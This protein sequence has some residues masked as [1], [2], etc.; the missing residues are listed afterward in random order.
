MRVVPSTLRGWVTGVFAV[1]GV[2]LL[3]WSI[4][5][6]SS[7]KAH[8]ET[9]RWDLAWSGFDTGLAVL[10]IATAVAL[11]RRSPWVGVLAAA[12]G[13]GLVVDAWFDIILES[14]ADEMRN[15]ILLAVFAELPIAAFCFWVA[16]RT[17]RFHDRALHLAA[18]RQRAAESDLVGVLEVPADREPT[19]E[20]RH[21]DP[22]A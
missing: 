4:W 11:H 5:L 8:H 21:A 14:H 7:L 16:R 1:C 9:N 13:T 17:E 3:P 18:A 22:A 15:S 12:T 10:F 2:G 19:R 20:S 6:S